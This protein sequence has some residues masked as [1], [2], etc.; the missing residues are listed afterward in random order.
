MSIK[1][2]IIIL[3]SSFLLFSQEINDT[4]IIVGDSLFIS[5]TLAVNDTLVVKDSVFVYDT[6]IVFPAKLYENSFVIERKIFLRND[7]R[8]TGDLIE[9]FQFNFIRNLG[10]PGQANETFIYGVGFDGISFLQDGILIND[11]RL[12]L[13]DLNLV[14]SEDIETIEIVPSPRG[15]LYSPFNN[16]IT[17]NFIT[18]DFIPAQPY[19]RIKY[20]QGPYGEAMVDGSFNA[21]FSRNFQFSFDVTN[22]K[23]DSSYTNTSF[24]TWMAKVK[25]RYYFTSNMYL[26]AT[27]NY[28]N[29]QTG[30]WQGVDADSILRIGI[31]LD[32]LLY[33]PDFAP[34]INTTL[35]QKDLLN[36]STIRLT[37]VQSENSRTEISLYHSFKEAKLE[38]GSYLEYDN[39]TIGLNV[40]Q[41]FKPSIFYFYLAGNYERNTL[42]NW[43]R[44]N[45]ETE[46]FIGYKKHFTRFYSVIG[47]VS[48]DIIENLNPSIF[49]KISNANREYSSLGYDI[50]SSGIGIDIKYIPLDDIILYAGF[51][52]FDKSFLENDKTNIFEFGAKYTSEY[53]LADLKYFRMDNTNITKVSR[54]NFI[55]PVL[56]KIGEISGIGLSSNASYLFLRFEGNTAVYFANDGDLNSVP[57]FSFIGG[58]YYWGNLFEDNLNLKTG[59]NFT[60]TGEINLITDQYGLLVV[61]PS[62][63][64]NFILSGEIRKAAI[65][66]FSIEN[67]IDK[68]YFITPYY[69]M[70]GISLRFGLAW[71]FLN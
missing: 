7:Y 27:Y 35:K 26:S 69:P 47:S 42:G 24:S 17:V 5:D 14:Q 18:R 65:V 46:T 19:S 6:S 56:H 4:T 16:P 11:R 12:N 31:P 59:L 49:F 23:Y 2:I 68:Q 36:F 50:V 43:Y 20:Y 30:N 40:N 55:N 21:L 57:D 54:I 61:Q 3:A 70:P 1:A 28:A 58:L 25:A 45:S 34:V 60:Y 9:P 22:R 63:K 62:Y 66:Y 52:L 51:S 71:E 29:K 44:Y 64:L 38:N 33:E 37:N 13:L 39:T 15:F 41:T 48:G 10:T 32:D 8:Y 53:I 67:I